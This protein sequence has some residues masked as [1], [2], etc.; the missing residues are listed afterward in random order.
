MQLTESLTWIAR[1]QTVQAGFQL[2]DWSRRGFYDRTNFGGTFY[3]S[4][5]D[6]YAAGRPYAFTQQQGNGDLALLEKQVGAYIKDDWQVRPGLSLSVRPALR[7]AELLSRQQQCRAA[8]R[9]SPTRRA[10]RKTNVI[11]GGVRPLQRSQRPRHYRRRCCTPQ[12][13][14]LQRYVITDPGVSRSVRLRGGRRAAAE[15]SCSSRRTCRFR[16]RCSSASASIVNCERDDAVARLHRRARLRPVPLARRQRAA[17]AALSRASRS[18]RTARSARSN[19]PD[20][21]PATRC[22]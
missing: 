7:L 4:N 10:N 20:A 15:S 5:L 1:H 21:R 6:A 17:A 12:P 3:F 22:K 11:R 9:R 14:G 19:R 8:R 2:P 13:G 18:G 16:R